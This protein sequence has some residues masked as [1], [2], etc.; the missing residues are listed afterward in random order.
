MVNPLLA[1]N[2]NAGSGMPPARLKLAEAMRL[3][4]RS[5]D[6][7]SITTAEISRTAGANEALIYRYFK[8]KRG[9]LH[10]VLYDY[11][12]D[13]HTE[14]QKE[15]E[16]VPTAMGKLECLIRAHIRMY[17]SNRVFARILLLEVRNFPAYFESDTYRLIKNYGQMVGDIIVDGV[18]AGEIRGDVPVP[19]IRDLILGGIEHFCI[20]EVIFNHKIHVGTS[21]GYLCKL[22]FEGIKKEQSKPAG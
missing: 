21:A 18:A 9:L 5:K 6:F 14:I 10:Q 12:L 8:D 22:I 1:N 2:A 19:R 13:F 3:L 20:A 7:N 11:L 15:I 17:D 16:A 4:L